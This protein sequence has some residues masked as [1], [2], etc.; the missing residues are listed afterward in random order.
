VIVANSVSK[1]ILRVVADN[2]F[3]K[4]DFVDYFPSYEFVTMSSRRISWHTDQIHVDPKMVR[5]IMEN[6]VKI[7]YHG[8]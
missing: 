4:F 1:S 3:R 2:L 5:H 6:F 8:V 7:Y